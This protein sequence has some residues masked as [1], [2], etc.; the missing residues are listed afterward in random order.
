M[1]SIML[2]AN[3]AG[4]AERN[5]G[6]GFKEPETGPYKVTITEVEQNE[7]EGKYSVKFQTIIA[8]GDFSGSE[9]RLFL[10]TDLSK[11]GNL[12]SWK[13][14]LLSVGHKPAQI[15]AGEIEFDAADMKG[16]TAFIYY[17]AK[18]PNDATSQSDRQFIT[19]EQYQRLVGQNSGSIAGSAPKTTAPQM[20]VSTPKP[21]GSNA[22]R[23]MLGR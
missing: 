21:G 16:K 7:K 20:T 22:L 4:V 5:V 8:E 1:S 19:P 12:R 6:G 13:T 18:D 9:T 3:F 14:A 2:K 11:P 10:G 15:E 23:S 17:K